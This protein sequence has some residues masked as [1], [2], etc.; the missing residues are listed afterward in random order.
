MFTTVLHHLFFFKCFVSQ[1]FSN[2]QLMQNISSL[3][4]VNGSA[5]Q[6]PV[7]EL[8]ITHFPPLRLCNGCIYSL[9]WRFRFPIQKVTKTHL[10]KL[11]FYLIAIL[12]S[13]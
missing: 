8:N 9:P 1:M 2:F 13:Y 10:N 3:T 5:F 12:C 6:Q 7:L 11:Q 4:A